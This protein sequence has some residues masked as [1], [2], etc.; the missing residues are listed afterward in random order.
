M[1]STSPDSSSLPVLLPTSKT[2]RTINVETFFSSKVYLDRL[3][4]NSCLNLWAL[5]SVRGS[6]FYSSNL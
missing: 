6:V 5:K 2:P 4:N 3:S 1:T